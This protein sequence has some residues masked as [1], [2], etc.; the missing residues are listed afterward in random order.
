MQNPV[1]ATP[2]DDMGQLRD[3]ADLARRFPEPGTIGAQVFST[4]VEQKSLPERSRSTI[5]L[6]PQERTLVSMMRP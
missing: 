3:A 1:P 2:D 5:A 6:S 4:F